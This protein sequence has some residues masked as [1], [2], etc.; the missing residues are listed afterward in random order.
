MTKPNKILVT[1]PFPKEMIT[2]FDACVKRMEGLGYE[3]VLDSRARALK[4]DELLEYAPEL[5]AD[6]CSTD[7]WTRKALEAAPNL[8]VIS[9]M[10]VGYDS[11][12]V[13][14]ATEKGVG[15]TITVAANAPDVAEYAFTMML[16]LSRKLKEADK[17]VRGGEWKKVFSHSLYNKTLGII[18]LGNIGKRVAKLT[19]GFDMKIIAYDQYKDEAYAR[20]NGIMYCSLE[21]LV[22]ESD[23]ISIHAPL[24]EETK[25]L[26]SEAQFDMMKPTTI[27]INCARGGIVDEE[28]LY[29]AL[30]DG[31]I[32]GAGL[33]VFEDEPVK[34]DNPLLTLD[35]VIVSPHTAGMTREGRSHLVEIAFQNAIDVI[36]G[37]A[38][39][40]LV[41]PEI[42]K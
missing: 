42:F 18:G 14:A 27:V 24:M 11:I 4:E 41:N 10:G 19:C 28:A 13:P 34:M 16:A 2:S 21:D 22:K 23:I 12:D 8:K 33:D 31:K 9:R 15:V 36:E 38:P 5:V 32:M 1:L 37:K 17:L 26:I 6:I 35:N 25:G 39:R 30:K 7:A 40:G 3:V 20:E 29:R